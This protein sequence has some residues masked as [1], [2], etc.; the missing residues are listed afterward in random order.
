MG[1]HCK[2]VIVG[3]EFGGSSSSLGICDF[4]KPYSNHY[5]MGHSASDIHPWSPIHHRRCCYRFNFTREL[6][7]N[8]WWATD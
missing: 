4:S 2:V 7:E 1:E 6:S 5:S 8:S 3:G